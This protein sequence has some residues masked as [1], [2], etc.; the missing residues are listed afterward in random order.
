MLKFKLLFLAGLLALLLT[1]C[2]Q[3]SGAVVNPASDPDTAEVLASQSDPAVQQE[4]P[5]PQNAPTETPVDYCRS[6]H[7]DQQQLMDSADTGEGI[8]ATIGGEASQTQT[9]EKVWVNGE[10][11][12]KTVHGHIA[13]VDCHGGV[14]SPEKDIA[15]QGVIRNPSKDPEATCGECHKDIVAGNSTNL[16]T[17]PAS[18]LKS[19]FVR[20]ILLD[21]PILSEAVDAQCSSCHATCGDCHVSK[22]ALSGGGLLNGHVFSRTPSMTLNCTV[23]HASLEGDEFLGNH[24]GLEADVHY[25]QGQMTCVNCH[26]GLQMHGQPAD[27]NSCHPG[28]QDSE[29]MP[30]DH[31]YDSIQTPRCESCHSKVTSGQ[32]DVLMHKMHGADLS[33]QVCHSIAYTNCEGCHVGTDADGMPTSTLDAV[34]QTFLIGRNPIQSYERPYRYVTVRHVPVSPDTFDAY[35]P[36]LLSRFN[37][38]ATWTYTTPHNIQR[39]TPQTKSCNT[40]HGDPNLFLTA[41]KV[42]PGELEANKDVI[43]D[44]LPPLISS[45]DQIP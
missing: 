29:L 34:Y 25:S 3:P 23:C 45:G 20:S 2:G 42:A 5:T 31:L 44:Q 15:H 37:T 6:C 17:N 16:H 19:V 11:L 4:A 13:C 8:N 10:E 27:C 41:D 21:H 24:P 32:D 22:P 9:W 36:D 38:Q 40:C 7:T 18:F 12:D 26:T 1:A 30:A 28:P 33:C 43:I 14:Q 39:N 35:G